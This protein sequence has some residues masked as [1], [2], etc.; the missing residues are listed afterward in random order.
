LVIYN[1]RIFYIKGTENTRADIFSRKEEYQEE[2]KTKLYIIFRK[3]DN[4]LVFNSAQLTII[5]S[6]HNNYLEKQI[7]EYYKNNPT[8]KRVLKKPNE[9]FIIKDKVIYFYKKIYISST[10]VK[11]F[12]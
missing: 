12:T 3:E 10:L 9:G 2:E 11:Q 1:F 7:Q 8:I 6:L 5:I 4:S